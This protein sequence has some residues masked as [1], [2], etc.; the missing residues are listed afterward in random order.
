MSEVKWIK[1]NTGMFEDEKIRLIESLPEADTILVIWVKLLAQAGKTNA[2]GYIFLSKNIPYTD[3]M[4]ATL[5]NRKLS[6][7]RMA[8]QILEEFGMI[9][10][11]D[12]HFI[13]IAN[14]EKHQNVD[15][16]DR[17][18]EQTRKRVA[19]HR[20]RQ[21]QA[22]LEAPAIEVDED[23]GNGCN[24]TGNVTVTDG[25]ALEE[26]LDKE[27]DKEKDKKNKSRKQVYDDTS[28]Y[29]QLANRLY[30]RILE[31]NPGH[32]KPNLQKWADDARKMIEIDERTEEAIIYLIDWVQKHDFWKANVL[33][34]DKLRKK[35]DQLVIQVK[36]E[37]DK[38][39]KDAAKP[40]FG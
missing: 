11:D 16:L 32:K 37:K 24:V 9:E 35:F 39:K 23:E 12:K 34:M 6:T 3:E 19:E 1:L 13:S 18:R 21:R 25:N 27:R 36:A 4:L 7:V 20:E 28:V 26:E 8:L 38:A 2:S 15:G 29:S 10:I 22:L 14:W 40:K 5:F 17:I 31:N 30:A 33:S